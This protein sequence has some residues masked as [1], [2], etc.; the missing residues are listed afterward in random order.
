MKAIDPSEIIT[1]EIPRR[2]SLPINPWIRMVARFFD[3]ALFFMVLRMCVRATVK[4]PA[5]DD[6]VPLEFLAWAPVETLFLWILGTTPGKWFL[7]IHLKKG[8]AKRL[9]IQ[10]AFRRSFS[11]WLKGLG[12]GIPVINALCMLAAYQRL[13]TYRTTSWD[14]QEHVV[15]THEAIP[16]WRFFL[17][18][19]LALIGMIYYSYWKKQL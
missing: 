10:T 4:I 2:K 8:G 14:V 19:T 9:D 18:F 12:M 16:K 13:R 17:L 15:V 11:V 6:W 1:G 7:R 3:Y 5:F